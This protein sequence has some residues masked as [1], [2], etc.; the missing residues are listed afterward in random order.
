MTKGKPVV[1]KEFKV[2]TKTDLPTMAIRNTVE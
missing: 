2:L 1:I